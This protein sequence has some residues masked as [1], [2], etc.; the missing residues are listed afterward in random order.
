MAGWRERSL[1]LLRPAAGAAIGCALACASAHAELLSGYFPTG[2]PGYGRAPGVT[3]ASRARPDFDPPGIRLGGFVLHP[4]LGQGLGYDSNVFGA[5]NPRG[6]WIVGTHPSLLVASDWSRH[7]IGGYVDIDDR[8]Y[9]DQPHQGRTNWT[10]SLGG[11][12]SVGHDQLTVSAAHFSLHQDR[13]ELDA[14]PSDAPVAYQVEDVRAAYTI[15]LNRVSVKPSLAFSS[16]RYD[17]TTIFGAPA[18]QGYRNRNVVQAAVTT[19]YELAPQSNLLLVARVTGSNYVT[20]QLGAPSRNST[21]YQVLVGFADDADAVW[22]YRVLLGWEMRSFRAV[23]YQASQVPIAEATVIWSPSGMTALT[24]SL[25]RSTEDA[26]QEGIAGYTY[27]SAR[28]VLDHEYQRNVLLQVSAGM[29]HADY[30]QGGGQSSGFSLGGGV[31]WLLNRHMRLSATYD[32]TDQR[33][34]STPTLQTT[35]NYTRSLG[36]LTLRLGM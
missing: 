22:R 6:S 31:T 5:A 10:A 29:Q 7:R 30:L 28:L 36:L 27:T 24:A 3:V 33:G 9:L 16:Y 17:D 4:Q 25:S 18:P 13:T 35:G 23:Q 20:P 19:R 32:F 1:R 12:L 15:A 21:G 26:A 11:T 34:S 2:V 8:R 14:L